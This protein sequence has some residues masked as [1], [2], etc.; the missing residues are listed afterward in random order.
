MRDG[1]PLT[2]CSAVP[3][4]IPNEFGTRVRCNGRSRDGL[5][6]R[7]L[8]RERHNITDGPSLSLE[9]SLFDVAE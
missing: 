4:V 8:R 1:A 6:T 7:R 2:G 9:R 5:F 3:P